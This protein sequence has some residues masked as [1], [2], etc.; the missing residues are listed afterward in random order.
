M[1]DLAEPRLHFSK[2][3]SLPLKHLKLG[4]FACKQIFQRKTV[5]PASELLS[6]TVLIKSSLQ[7]SPE[8][9]CILIVPETQ[10][11]GDQDIGALHS[12]ILSFRDKK[13]IAVLKEKNLQS[14]NW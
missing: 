14:L 8:D 12:K 5:E 11:P 4:L 13:N 10:V 9:A 1:S 7:D 2:H 3:L 6:L